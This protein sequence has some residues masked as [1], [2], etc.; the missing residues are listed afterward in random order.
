MSLKYF[1]LFKLAFLLLLFPFVTSNPYFNIGE[2]GGRG[3]TI[4]DGALCCQQVELLQTAPTGVYIDLLDQ[5]I[6]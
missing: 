4:L 1:S 3:V 6:S 2:K 5:R